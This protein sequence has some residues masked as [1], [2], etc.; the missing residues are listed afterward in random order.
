MNDIG[1]TITESVRLIS[2]AGEQIESL[3]IIIKEE[4]SEMIN[5]LEYFMRFENDW[6]SDVRHDENEWVV[7]DYAHGTCL[8]LKGKGNRGAAGHLSFQISL[9]GDGMKIE[10]N[11]EPLLHICW[12][13]DDINFE[14]GNYFGVPFDEETEFSVENGVIVNFS[15]SYESVSD[16]RWSYSLRLTSINTPDD[17]KNKIIKPVVQ[18]FNKGIIEAV[19]SLEKLKEK[20]L[21]EYEQIVDQPGHLRLIS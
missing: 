20:G 16:Q 18:L 14:D 21:V 13:D 19:T 11:E 15:P 7:T 17:V 10:G 4:L 2:K 1:K 9:L 6:I 3:V 8:K 12:W 5:K